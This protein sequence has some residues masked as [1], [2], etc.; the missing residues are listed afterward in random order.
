M[1]IEWTGAGS[2]VLVDVAK[3]VAEEDGDVDTVLLLTVGSERFA[4]RTAF[5]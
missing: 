3:G 1:V 5:C 2:G 4:S